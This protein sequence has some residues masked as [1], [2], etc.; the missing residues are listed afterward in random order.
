M[1][2]LASRLRATITGHPRFVTWIVFVLALSVWGWWAGPAWNPTPLRTVL[3]PETD[4]TAIGGVE[5]VALG[6]YS[7]ALEE[8]SIQMPDGEPI[9]AT[10]RRPIGASGPLPAMMFIHGTGTASHTSFH[11]EAN[12]LASAGIITFVPDKRLTDYSLTHRDYVALADD[13]SVA[14]NA[15]L[16]LD[17]IDRERVGLYAVSEGCFVAPIVAAECS[18]VRYAVL[19][20]APAVPIREQGALAADSYLRALGAPSPVLKAIPKLLGQSFADGTFG[21]IDFDPGDY[22]SRMS[23]PVFMA[24]GT[25][26]MSMPLI[27]GPQEVA[28]HLAEGGAPA[29]TIRYYEDADHG[30]QVDHVLVLTAMRDIGDWVRGLPATAGAAPRIAGAQPTQE[31]QA[32]AV[33]HTRWFAQGNTGLSI[34]ARAFI[35]SA[36]GL[37]LLGLMSLVTHR[38]ASDGLIRPPGR[39]LALSGV[40]TLTASIALVAYMLA[41]AYLAT[42]YERNALIVQGGWVSVRLLALFAAWRFVVAAFAWREARNAAPE[43]RNAR[44]A[45]VVGAITGLGQL[46]LLM[47][48]AYWGVFP[49]IF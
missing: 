31:Y 38:R 1:S 21:Y 27:Q 45:T 11:R 49:S 29:P 19:I 48:L 13:F 41:V 17:G 2:R 20:S 3:V 16:G 28:R 30:L 8:M 10:I 47:A 14:Y 37:I 44:P 7:V 24:Y 43:A 12:K 39:P 32:G 9:T 15:L 25:A 5:S 26:D 22:E 23:Q 6:T 35:A 18:D 46:T 36:G 34:L 4:D 42:N 33:E 40:L